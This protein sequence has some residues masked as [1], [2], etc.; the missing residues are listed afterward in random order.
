M[1]TANTAGLLDVMA[2]KIEAKWEDVDEDRKK[3]FEGL[4]F[5]Q[6]GEV[7]EATKVFRRAARHCPEPFSTMAKMAHGRCEVVRGHDCA[8][9]RIFR[10][11]ATSDGPQELRQ[12]AWMEVA[13]LARKRDDQELYQKARDGVASGPH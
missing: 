4:R 6:N 1:Q 9:L 8:A 13:D 5:L 7:E 11:V 10:K 2:A 12:L 3:F